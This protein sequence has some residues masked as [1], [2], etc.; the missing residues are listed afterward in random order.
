MFS[1]LNFHNDILNSSIITKNLFDK[2][3]KTDLLLSSSNLKEIIDKSNNVGI[4]GTKTY[5][6]ITY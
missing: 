2:V 5:E 3:Y 1:Q 6:K 4:I